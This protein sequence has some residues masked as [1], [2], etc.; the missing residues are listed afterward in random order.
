MNIFKKSSLLY[1]RVGLFAND[2]N[3]IGLELP[4]SARF[5]YNND[6]TKLLLFNYF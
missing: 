2:P 1:I 3:V 5:T 4:G 6:S